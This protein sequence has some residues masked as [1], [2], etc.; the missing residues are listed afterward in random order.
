MAYQLTINGRYI[1]STNK[2]TFTNLK[3]KV[4]G[5]VNY[6]EAKASSFD[7]TT[8]AINENVLG[9][10]PTQFQ[11]QVFYKCEEL[12]PDGT[13]GNGNI[14]MLW[15]EIIDG[16]YSNILSRNLNYDVKFTVPAN[17]IANI[18]TVKED[19]TLYMHNKFD[20]DIEWNFTGGDD[21]N[22]LDIVEDQLKR[23]LDVLAQLYSL[24]SLTPL[25]KELNDESL[26]KNIKEMGKNVT[27]VKERISTIAVGLS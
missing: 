17:S 5:I 24:K 7:I 16:K 4:L 14:I 9:N 15:A 2:N 11:D 25:I 12:S 8:L 1:I 21:N 26:L 27:I 3:I 22:K 20:I 18:S 6:E 19:V 10:E 23:A 13:N